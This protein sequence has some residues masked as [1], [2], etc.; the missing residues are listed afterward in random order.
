[1]V[2]D[3]NT[4][5]A[6]AGSPRQLTAMHTQMFGLA[7]ARD[8][9]TLVYGTEDAGATYLW[10]VDAVS[11]NPPERLEAAGWGARRPAAGR[12]RDR[13]LFAR[14]RYDADIYAVGASGS[15]RPIIVSSFVEAFPSYS[16]DGSRI[17][18]MRSADTTEIW[19]AAADGSEAHQL[20]HDMSPA[21][22]APKW[23]PDGRTIAF[24][25]QGADKHWHCWTIDV[26]G[27]NLRRIA[28][29]PGDQRAPRWSRDGKWIYF[30]KGSTGA[31]IW[32]IPVSGGREQQITHGG[33][34]FAEESVDG[35]T[36]VYSRP[37]QQAGSEL[38][39]QPLTG[40]SPRRL[41]DCA[42][43]F[44]VESH[45]IYYHPCP[46]ATALPLSRF[47]NSEIR[48][49]DP[50]TGHDRLIRSVE[51][52]GYGE[53]FWGPELTPDGTTFVDGRVVNEGEDLMMIEN[54]R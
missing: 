38:F 49:F 20:T 15:L 17:A 44:S 4:D 35:K 2:V 32:R 31:D 7:W 25:G 27:A 48:L 33:G 45:G 22:W 3:V 29:G 30:S 37:L 26:D 23:S 6:E 10:R 8:G 47:R 36:L 42:Y 16:P 51:R 28:T 13:L 9:R 52:I 46:R 14:S 34:E 54:F 18:F 43:G 12:S 40:G 41:V 11:G 1:M 5:L 39:A 50:V 21:Q 19:V 24:S 53:L